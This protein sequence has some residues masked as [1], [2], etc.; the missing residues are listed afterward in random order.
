MTH[1]A[2][3]ARH[4]SSHAIW[5][6]QEW[7][8]VCVPTCPFCCAASPELS[9]SGDAKLY[10]LNAPLLPPVSSTV[11][12]EFRACTAGNS[13]TKGQSWFKLGPAC[14]I[15]TVI[16]QQVN[17]LLQQIYR[18]DIDLPYGHSAAREPSLTP[19]T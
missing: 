16:A 12:S 8:A 15:C 17:K 18:H 1:Y 2:N 4:A 5:Q 10:C 3:T 7:I 9:A 19:A 11:P 14:P 13:R 6:M